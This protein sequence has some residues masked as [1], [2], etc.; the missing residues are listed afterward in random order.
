MTNNINIVFN[1]NMEETNNLKGAKIKSRKEDNSSEVTE[2]FF[3]TFIQTLVL[4]QWKYQI[5]ARK[6]RKKNTRKPT[7]NDIFLANTKKLFN[8]TANIVA[9]HKAVYLYDL[10]DIMDQMPQ[11]RGIKHDKDFGKIKIANNKILSIK[12]MKRIKFLTKLYF[13]IRINNDL[14][15]ILIESINKMKEIR[16]KKL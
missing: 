10:L 4:S 6:Y 16:N 11:K 12:A 7:K 3:K 14:E 5:M 2:D 13:I 15:D 1:K 8:S 9:E